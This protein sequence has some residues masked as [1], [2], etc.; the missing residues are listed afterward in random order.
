MVACWECCIHALLSK[1]FKRSVKKV[2]LFLSAS[3]FICVLWAIKNAFLVRKIIGNQV[4]AVVACC[5]VM[6]G[7]PE[8]GQSLA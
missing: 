7:L 3:S 5:K 8:Q 1:I 2:T 4:A 6:T